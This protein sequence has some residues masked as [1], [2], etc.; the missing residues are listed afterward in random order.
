M[1]S[2][3]RAERLK[4]GRIVA[5]K[6]MNESLP[7]AMSSRRRFE[8]EATAMA[9]L[10]HPHCASVLD[11]GVHDSRPYVVMDFVSGTNLTKLIDQGPVPIAR[12]VEITRQVLSGLAHAHALGIVHRDIKPAN[13]VLSQKAGLGDHAKILDFGL[14]RLSEESSNLTAGVILGTPSYMAP[15]QIR[16]LLIDGRTDLYACGVMLFELLTGTKPFRSANNEPVEVCM[17]HIT[18]PA[19]RLAE[20]LPGTDFGELEAIVARAL[21]KERDSRFATAGEF[22]DALA[23]LGGRP[24]YQTPPAGVPVPPPSEAT[25]R[26]KDVSPMTSAATSALA[27]ETSAPRPPAPPRPA[28][29]RTLVIAGGAIAAIAIVI[30]VAVGMSKG[31][32]DSAGTTPPPSPADSVAVI[33]TE[34][35]AVGDPVADLVVRAK[36]LAASGRLKPAIDLLTKARRHHPQDAR[37]P[38]QAGMLYV[39]KMYFGDGLPLVRAA[40]AID[41]AYRSNPE[42]IKALLRGFNA[43]ASYDGAIARFLR[44]DIGAA[45]KPYLEETATSH[46]NAIVRKRAAAELKR[47]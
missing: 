23:A 3:Y 7:D 15:E 6:V 20:K 8:R 1:G 47:Y 22:A 13:I 16:G 46:P 43:K 34:P 27:V 31:T 29:R 17:M 19:P 4:L 37:L 24:S 10:E 41:P 30:A 11:I 26:L 35:E 5:I 44:E 9:K 18:V 38:F 12:A 28:S 36:E 32:T 25:V 39:D 42:L 40:F 14:A 2:V 45:A 33:S 21:E